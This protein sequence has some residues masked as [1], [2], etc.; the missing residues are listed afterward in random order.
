[1][2]S[3]IKGELTEVSETS[4]VVETSSGIGMNIIVP[5]TVMD[6]L[7]PLGSVVKIHTYL[8]VKE[9]S[10]TLYGFI[11]R[12]DVDIFRL[13]ISVNGVGPKGALAILSTITPDDLRFAVLSDDVKAISKAPGI[14]AKTA[15]RMIIELKDK[16]KLEDAFEIRLSHEEVDDLLAG[17]ARN[18]TVQALVALGYG[19]SE[20]ARAVNMVDS[21]DSMDSEQLIKA[22]LKKLAMI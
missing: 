3:Y 13:L 4:I 20:A 16:L 14:G 10:M 9:D 7:P 1:M 15:Q 6:K 21:A 18:D 2:I 12:E 17:D 5:Q 11:N 8:N 19:R 22:A